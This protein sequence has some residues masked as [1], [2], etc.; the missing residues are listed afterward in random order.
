MKKLL[1]ILL[2]LACLAWS[3]NYGDKGTYGST[4]Y[5]ETDYGSSTY[6][7][8][9]GYSCSSEKSGVKKAKKSGKAA[10]SSSSSSMS[11]G[12]LLGNLVPTANSASSASGTPAAKPAKKEPEPLKP[13]KYRLAVEVGCSFYDADLVGLDL[14]Y[15]GNF[16]FFMRSG[17]GRFY[18]EYGL[19]SGADFFN[20]PRYDDPHIWWNVLALDAL[21]QLGIELGRSSFRFGTYLGGLFDYK[22]ISTYDVAGYG[23]GPLLKNNYHYGVSLGWAYRLSSHFELGVVFK[24]DL[25]EINSDIGNMKFGKKG[26]ARFAL[27]GALTF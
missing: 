12:S 27:T 17:E 23:D 16:Q 20:V 21:L 14:G 19:G 9:S 26:F 1:F 2:A 5:G 15:L 11:L 6:G 7:C 24:D 22:G 25:S 10:P 3:D 13:Y 18:I 4:A 8:S